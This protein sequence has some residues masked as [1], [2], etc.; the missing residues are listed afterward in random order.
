MNLKKMEKIGIVTV[1]LTILFLTSC[2]TPVV[3][4]HK[5]CP[6][7]AVWKSEWNPTQEYAQAIADTFAFING[8]PTRGQ[9]INKRLND[10]EKYC[11][12]MRIK[13]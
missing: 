5:G 6:R 10:L 12:Q 4:N 7:S 2:Q 11:Y 13:D 1:V 9:L 8:K 3:I